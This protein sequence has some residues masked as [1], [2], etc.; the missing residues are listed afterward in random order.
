MKK[1]IVIIIIVFY[2]LIFVGFSYAVEKSISP[3]EFW[4]RLTKLDNSDVIIS[5]V[6]TLIKQFYIKGIGEGIMLTGPGI[7]LDFDEPTLDKMR[8]YSSFILEN[9][10][11]IMEIMDDLYKD[12]ANVKIKLDWMCITAVIKLV[13][14]DFEV[15]LQAG[16]LLG[17]LLEGF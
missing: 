4:N 11:E 17:I 3:G 2:L 1:T 9:N 7:G 10:Q 15:K 16:R 8:F 13:G 5:D 12:P 14:D 6:S